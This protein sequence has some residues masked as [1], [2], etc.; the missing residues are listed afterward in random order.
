MTDA[1]T[2]VR[3]L[4]SFT[5]SSVIPPFEGLFFFGEERGV[6]N[7]VEMLSS[8]ACIGSA[9]IRPKSRF[10][11]V[12]SA[13]AFDLRGWKR[14]HCRSGTGCCQNSVGTEVR[15][16]EARMLYDSVRSRREEVFAVIM[17]TGYC[18]KDLSES[19]SSG[20]GVKSRFFSG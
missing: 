19:A 8:S 6:G 14:G 3:S 4:A 7:R 15:I 20:I 17:D 16:R 18:K 2:V 13:S 1:V 5:C 12:A 11:E 9:K 10:I